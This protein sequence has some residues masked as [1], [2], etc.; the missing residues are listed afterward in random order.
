MIPS[1]ALIRVGHQGPGS[2][3]ATACGYASD[4]LAHFDL[5]FGGGGL[6]KEWQGGFQEVRQALDQDSVVVGHAVP[7]PLQTALELTRSTSAEGVTYAAEAFLN[8]QHP[9]CRMLQ[10][11]QSWHSM[12]LARCLFGQLAEGCAV[13]SAWNS[14]HSAANLLWTT[15]LTDNWPACPT[16]VQV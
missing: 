1:D 9:T 11:P 13:W 16:V 14:T 5:L 12:F 4:L 3:G 6:I 15:P 2:V 8:E 7:F 10:F